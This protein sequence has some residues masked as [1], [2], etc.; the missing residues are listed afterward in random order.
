M[1]FADDA[2]AAGQILLLKQWWDRL[3]KV[4]PDF[5]YFINAA[6][7]WLIVKVES[8]AQAK[9]VFGQS[10]VQRSTASG[11]TSV[12]CAL[13]MV[14]SYHTYLRIPTLCVVRI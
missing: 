4:G 2:T 7:S 11:Y 8:L 14:G 5:V 6:R 10:E 12:L 9:D 1:W 13:D 3:V